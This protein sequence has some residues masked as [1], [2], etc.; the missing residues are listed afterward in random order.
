MMH[1]SGR[2]FWCFVKMTQMKENV[3]STTC[4]DCLLLLA[5]ALMI[6][7]RHTEHVFDSQTVLSYEYSSRCVRCIISWCHVVDNFL[8]APPRVTQIVCSV[9]QFYSLFPIFLVV[10]QAWCV[11]YVCH[12]FLITSGSQIVIAT[13]RKTMWELLLEL[14]SPFSRG[15]CANINRIFDEMGAHGETFFE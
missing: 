12:L 2:E 3:R 4:N 1:E 5:S 15:S 11:S 7:S 8:W 6:P 13:K 10:E 14:F 9:W